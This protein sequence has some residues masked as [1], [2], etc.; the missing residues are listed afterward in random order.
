MRYQYSEN[1]TLRPTVVPDCSARQFAGP[2]APPTAIRETSG[3]QVPGC[4]ADLSIDKP[5]NR[6]L[7]VCSEHLK[8]NSVTLHVGE[9][10]FCQQCSRFHTVDAFD[11]SRRSCRDRLK[12]HNQR[13]K[14]RKEP[15]SEATTTQTSD[16][17]QGPDWSDAFYGLFEPHHAT[18]QFVPAHPGV[19]QQAPVMY[20]PMNQIFLPDMQTRM[21]VGGAPQN[22]HSSYTFADFRPSKF[23]AVHR[24]SESDASSVTS[25]APMKVPSLLDA[26]AVDIPAVDD[27]SLPEWDMGDLADFEP[28]AF[29]FSGLCGA[30]PASVSQTCHQSSYLCNEEL[31]LLQQL[32]PN[33]V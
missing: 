2:I 27:F 7:K 5:Y 16:S 31:E 18:S 21:W 1:Q 23:Q 22:D 28:D 14:R 20:Q 30:P 3:C 32:L 33:H 10:R 4:C 6:R 15:E 19:V 29:D 24:V 17:S 11:G 12:T 25:V 26:P 13:R 8:A 9:S